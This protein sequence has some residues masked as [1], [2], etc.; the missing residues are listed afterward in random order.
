MSDL[1]QSPTRATATTGGEPLA[2]PHFVVRRSGDATRPST[3]QATILAARDLRK[4]Y[5]KGQVSI[6]VLRGVDIEV[7]SCEFLSVVGKSGSG[8]S[9]LMHLLAT[10]DSPDSGEIDFHAKRID[11][12]PAPRRDRLRNQQIGIVFQFYHLLPELTT[13]ENV[14]LPALI[15]SPIW[16]YWGRR[17]ALRERASELIHQVGLEHRLR[18]RPRELSGGEM[19]R[20][21]IARALMNQPQVLLA[22]EPT[23]N[24]DRQTGMQILELLRS[25]NEAQ[26]LTIV[27]VT[28][29]SA[30]AKQTDRVVQL[31]EGK[32]R[33]QA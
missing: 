18:H 10:L 15:D 25:L 23:G 21:A 26:K 17:K 7:K 31:V 11:N 22:D 32:V 2:G 13:L 12:L 3:S 14:L 9:T 8:K 4:S 29:D 6:P 30:L 5:R 24:L 27:M 19:Q 20:V 28:H 1:I 33:L 16:S